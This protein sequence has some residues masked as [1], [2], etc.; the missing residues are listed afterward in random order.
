MDKTNY[1]TDKC[2]IEG[3]GKVFYYLTEIEI[4]NRKKNKSKFVTGNNKRCK[5]SNKTG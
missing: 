1:R 4:E 2:S 5:T 3:K